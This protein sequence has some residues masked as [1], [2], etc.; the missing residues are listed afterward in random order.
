MNQTAVRF[1]LAARQTFGLWH[2]V[3]KLLRLR[4]TIF[5]S[6]LRRAKSRRKIATGFLALVILGLAVFLFWL[7][8]V[9]LRYLQS[10]RIIQYI[11][12]RAVI[13]SMPSTVITLA[14]FV[15]LLTNFA[16]LLQ[17]LY[18]TN[19]LDFLLAAPLPI[20]AVFMA[21]LLQ[22]LLPNF[23]LICL[24]ALP[25]LFGLGVMQGYNILFY[26]LVV[27][28]MATVSLLGAGIS[29]LLV[30]SIVRVAPARRVAEILGFFG[31]VISLLFSQS[32]QL[33]AQFGSADGGGI[34][35]AISK[36]SGMDQPWSPL[37]WAGRGLVALG[38]G[39]WLVGLPLVFLSLGLTG[40]LFWAA[41]GLSERLY[42][43]GWARMQDSPRKKKKRQQPAGAAQSI[44]LQPTVGSRSVL[45]WVPAPVRAV[46]TKDWRLLRRDL[47]NLSQLIAPLIFSAIYAVSM[48]RGFQSIQQ[49]PGD[50]FSSILVRSQVYLSLG[51]PMFFG[52]TFL[53]NLTINAFSR[54]GKSYW[55]LKASP[56]TPRRLMA[57]KF[58][59]SYLPSL[60]FQ[61]ILFAFVI[62]LHWPGLQTVIYALLMSLFYIAGLVG[63]TLTFGAYGAKLDWDDPRKMNSGTI[64]CFGFI[65]GVVYVVLAW[66]LFFLPPALAPVF[67]GPEWLGQLAG[68]IL[69]GGLS[70]ACALIPPFQA[71][72]KVEKIG[73]G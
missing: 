28:T 21:K 60:V 11:D 53:M 51:L 27:I 54:E 17:V 58:I 66:G 36:L 15:F 48:V 44:S 46:V 9:V 42:Y 47:R 29:S 6:G 37:S 70:L 38:E 61:W 26:P 14:F 25:L 8:L 7:S 41:L 20:R 65:A 23:G 12:L 5:W 13:A 22:A 43:S 55:L 40:G 63:L 16:A 71:L 45:R 62:V 19:D 59:T 67:G 4:L 50:V 10:P 34:T 31:A 32:G 72:G 64:G 1:P 52:W 56:L 30:M 69:G 33:F 68:L 39:N 24:F 49:V 35:S 73:M 2:Y 18:L 57:A 3:W